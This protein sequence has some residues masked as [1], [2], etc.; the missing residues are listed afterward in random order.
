MKRDRTAWESALRAL[1][2][3]ILFETDPIEGVDWVIA[4]IV[5][6]PKHKIPIDEWLW[7]IR[8]ALESGEQ[9][10]ELYGILASEDKVRAFL[11]EMARRLAARLPAP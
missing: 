2:Y 6:D 1:T 8:T 4:K 10:G 7:A 9:L 3:P 11:E 5:D